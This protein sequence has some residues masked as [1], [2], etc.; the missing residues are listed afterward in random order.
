MDPKRLIALKDGEISVYDWWYNTSITEYAHLREIALMV[1]SVPVSA[2]SCERNWSSFGFI[3]NK[4]RNRLSDKKAQTLVFVY[5]N[6]REL[7]KKRK[8]EEGSSDPFDIDFPDAME[9]TTN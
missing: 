1:F 5:T 7:D 3:Q 2:A 6:M 4:L 9:E 8:R